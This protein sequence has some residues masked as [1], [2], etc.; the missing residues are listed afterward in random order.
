[1]TIMYD[2]IKNDD[3]WRLGNVCLWMSVLC[4]WLSSDLFPWGSVVR[5]NEIINVLAG[6]L[7]FSWRFLGIATVFLVVTVSSGIALIARRGQKVACFVI[8]VLLLLNTVMWGNFVETA[9]VDNENAEYYSAANLLSLQWGNGDYLPYGSDYWSYT[10][11]R[12]VKGEN[13]EVIDAQIE[14]LQVTVK[15]VSDKDGSLSVP[16]I[17]Y[18]HYY[19]E[20]IVSGN[21]LP[22]SCDTER[23]TVKV[24][25]PP[26][27]EG[28]VLVKFR[29][30]WFWRL[31]EAVSLGTLIGILLFR[32]INLHNKR[33]SI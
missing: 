6:M 11:D 12:S 17:Y 29:E 27:F 5:L 33:A 24:S 15:C 16:L 25:L 22:V 4:I 21:V 32:Y 19:A 1:L 30:P 8:I 3:L 26:E 9:L 20:D 18:R 13:V 31:S 7:Q 2:N 28:T 14:P 23:Y 10:T